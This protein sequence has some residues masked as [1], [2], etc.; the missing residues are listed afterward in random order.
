LCGTPAAPC[1]SPSGPF[2]RARASGI[3]REGPVRF[4]EAL[5]DAVRRIAAREL[6]IEVHQ[7]AANGHIEYPSHYLHG[8]DS[9]VGIVFEVTR[10]SGDVQP[11]AEADEGR[12]FSQL[13]DDM[14][15][16]QD[17]YLIEHRY[18]SQ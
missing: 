2:L 10:D 4:G 18:I 1:S 6:G 11:N 3:Y 13:P 8:L 14:H 16:D 7:A 15:A 17:Q 5:W 9:P 12:F